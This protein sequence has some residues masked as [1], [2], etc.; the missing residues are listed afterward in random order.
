MF[1]HYQPGT[2][3]MRQLTLDDMDGICSI[4]HPDGARSVDPSVSAAGTIEEA[5]CDP[6]PRHGFQSECTQPQSTRACAAAPTT[7]GSGFTGSV[8]IAA[9]ALL[10][11]RARRPR[12]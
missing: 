7:T 12:V 11:A 10:A 4:Y 9:A 8:A 5:A 1:A 3:T 2:M 6:T